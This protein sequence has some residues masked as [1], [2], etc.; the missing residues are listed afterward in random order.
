VVEGGR[1][2]RRN[3]SGPARLGVCGLRT[4]GTAVIKYRVRDVVARLRAYQDG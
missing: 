1:L 2:A 4:G 3:V